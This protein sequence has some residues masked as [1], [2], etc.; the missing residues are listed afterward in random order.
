MFTRRLATRAATF[1]STRAL[2]TIENK[3]AQVTAGYLAGFLGAATA[4]YAVTVM[5]QD[6]TDAFERQEERYEAELDR[7][8]QEILRKY[9]GKP[10]PYTGIDLQGRKI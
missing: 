3:T 6:R 2:S 10:L 8:R 1:T 4:F 9:P 7:E 5:C